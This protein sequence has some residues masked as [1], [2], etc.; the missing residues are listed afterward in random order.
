MKFILNK[1][2]NNRFTFNY[3][4]FNLKISPFYATKYNASLTSI[5]EVRFTFNSQTFSKFGD[6]I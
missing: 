5:G 2:K 1:L 4:S 3:P 6:V